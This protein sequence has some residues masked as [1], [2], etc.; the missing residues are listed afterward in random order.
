[1]RSKIFSIIILILFL[2][3]CKTMDMDKAIDMTF[4][5]IQETSKASRPI[6]DEEEYF[7]GRAVA[8]R[9]FQSY[10]LLENSRLTNYVNLIGNTV[11]LNSEKPFTYGGYH[12][13][14]LDTNEINAF[15]CPGG[16]IMITRGMINLANNED[17]LAAILAHEIA[18]INNRD[19]I[20]SIKQARW[21]EALTVIG[22]KAAKQYGSEDLVKLVNIFEGSI[23]DVL[24]TLVV[25]GYSRT[26]EYA[27]D[28][29]ALIYL[30]KAGYNPEALLN[31]LNK[32]KAQERISNTGF[33][34]THPDNEDR[35]TNIKNKIPE[36]N[37]DLKAFQNR[38][39]RFNSY[40]RR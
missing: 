17:E 29:K 8:A 16:I 40:L 24:K 18:H 20:E 4:T 2:A 30:A 15:A 22:T 19:G 35:I 13:A 10:P 27:A 9:L 3:S 5:V 26:Q 11:A 38:T 25:N 32:L 37:T 23:D 28:E 34:K 31:V 6:S 21:T 39:A 36:V 7:V 33:L 1:M 14:I 12:F